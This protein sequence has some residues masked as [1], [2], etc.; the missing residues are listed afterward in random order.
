[1]TVYPANASVAGAAAT[2]PAHAEV[3]Q[4][5]PEGDER[6][7]AVDRRGVERQEGVERRRAAGQQQRGGGQLALGQQGDEGDAPGGVPRPEPSARHRGVGEERPGPGQEHPLQRWWRAG[8]GAARR[9]GTAST[10]AIFSPVCTNEAAASARMPK[11]PSSARKGHC[12]TSSSELSSCCA[13]GEAAMAPSVCGPSQ[14]GRAVSTTTA[15]TTAR[16][17]ASAPRMRRGDSPLRRS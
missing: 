14:Y 13:G 9:R 1:M 8:I 2:P 16:R 11:A 5:R 15:K 17:H 6:A 7:Q 10:P 4:R 12:A 3:A